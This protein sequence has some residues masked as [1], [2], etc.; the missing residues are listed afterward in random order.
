M[1]GGREGERDDDMSV[2]HAT[3]DMSSVYVLLV[4]TDRHKCAS[5]RLQVVQKRMQSRM[6]VSHAR[7]FERR[8]D[9]MYVFANISVIWHA[10][11]LRLHC[12]ASPPNSE[13]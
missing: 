3:H 5:A 13:N 11:T 7:V 6:Q 2:Y 8:A 1:L 12:S 9:W 4:T 10:Q